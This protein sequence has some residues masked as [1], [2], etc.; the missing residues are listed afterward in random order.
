MYINTDINTD[1]NTDTS[2]DLS[3]ATKTDK[4]ALPKC[5]TDSAGCT[6]LT[7]SL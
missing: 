4:M 3:T 7:V 5:A 1:A 6:T 2:T